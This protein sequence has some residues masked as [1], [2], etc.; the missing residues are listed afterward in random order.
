MQNGPPLQYKKVIFQYPGGTR[1]DSNM[2]PTSL[3]IIVPDSPHP[4]FADMDEDA[5]RSDADHSPYSNIISEAE[6]IQDDYTQMWHELHG[7][8]VALTEFY[9]THFFNKSY[10]TIASFAPLY[11]DWLTNLDEFYIAW[12]NFDTHVININLMA[13]LGNPYPPDPVV[14][15]IW[16]HYPQMGTKCSIYKRKVEDLKT[17]TEN[18]GK[19]KIH[20]SW[21]PKYEKAV[22]VIRR[23]QSDGKM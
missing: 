11:K 8:Y 5:Q 3:D 1:Q 12:Y 21:A 17:E 9:K 18:R 6:R 16:E 23:S 20:A 4:A 10:A 22:K 14:L 7:A 19:P 15:Y 13:Y 2:L